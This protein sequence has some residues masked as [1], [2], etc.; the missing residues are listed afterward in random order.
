MKMTTLC[1]IE[2]EGK[3]L[4]LHRVKKHHDINA[5]KWI[6][7]GGHVENGETPEEC[8]L[9]EVKEETGLVLTAYRLRGL[10]TFLSDVCEPELMCVFT[11][12]AFDGEMIECDEGELAWVEKSDV[13]A[14]PTWEGDRVF[15][16]RLLSGDERFF[17]IKLRY[18]GDKL[19]EKK[20][21]DY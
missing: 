8:L 11:A 19:V 16:E 3:Y 5:G 12:D 13:L 10:V 15:L 9:R 20:I 17:S 18:E 21:T 14:L 7:V 6:G 1:Y 2:K 4:M